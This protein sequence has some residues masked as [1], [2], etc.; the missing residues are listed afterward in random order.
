MNYADV[1]RGDSV[2]GLLF[3]I[4]TKKFNR[5]KNLI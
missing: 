4:S 5:K 2:M 3:E 1:I